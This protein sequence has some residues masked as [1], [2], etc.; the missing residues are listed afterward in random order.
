VK[1]EQTSS[2]GEELSKT[3]FFEASVML[4]YMHHIFRVF[5]Y[6]NGLM[7]LTLQPKYNEK[8]MQCAIRGGVLLSLQETSTSSIK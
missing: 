1:D 8:N 3:G 6:D 7:H 4:L 2:E 5:F